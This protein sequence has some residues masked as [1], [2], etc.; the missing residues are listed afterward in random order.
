MELYNAIIIDDE[1]NGI[2]IMEHF[3]TK[4][5]PSIKIVDKGSTVEEAVKKIQ[6]NKPDILFL[7]IQLSNNTSFEILD[8]IDFSEIEI[9]FVTAFNDYAIKAFKYNAIDYILKPLSIEDL[10][11]ATNKAIKR[12]NERK[13]FE[14]ELKTKDKLYNESSSE[15]VTISSLDKVSLIKKDDII[16]CKS[17]G[18]YTTFYLSNNTEIIACKNL[19]EFENALCNNFFRIHHSYIINLGHLIKINKKAGNY[20][21]MSNSA[22]LP[23]AKRRQE[24]LNKL[25]GV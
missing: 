3:L 1:K 2:D 8:Q 24:T 17:D 14:K 20:C 18:R 13:E 21:E 9:I 4:F 10:I 25:L 23:I 12:I 16:F 5:C 6:L 15:I 19:G 7:D 22:L 11:I